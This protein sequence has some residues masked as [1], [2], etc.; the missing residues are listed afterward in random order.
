MKRLFGDGKEKPAITYVELDKV[1]EKLG[2]YD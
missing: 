1:K 2:Y